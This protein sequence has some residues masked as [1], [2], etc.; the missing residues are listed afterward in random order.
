[1]NKKSTIASLID[2]ASDHKKYYI[3][4]VI[5][6]V[7]GVACS[8]LPYYLVARIVVD[9]VNGVKDFNNY[10]NLCVI[11]MVSWFLRVLFH[12]IS[13]TLS[14]KAT[15]TVIAN[16]RKRSIEKLANMPLGDVLNIPS[17]TMKSIIV[18]KIDSIETTLAHVVPEITSN[19]LVPFAIVIYIFTIDWRMALASLITVP[20]GI[21]CYMM[22][23]KDYEKNYGNYIN[24]NKILNATS[25]EYVA[26]IQVIKAFNQSA[27]SYEK[28]TKAAYEA[29]HSAIDWMEKCNIYFSIALSVFPAVLIG[30]LPIGCM[31]YIN[32]SLTSENFINI[33]ILALGVM[34]PLITAVSYSDDIAKI[35]T[36][37]GDINSVLE[38]DNLNRPE[39]LNKKLSFNNIKL[40]NVCFS[41]DKKQVLN[42]VDLNIKG[43]QVNA[44]VGPSGGGKSTIAKL[45]ASLWDVDK[46]S[47]EIGGINIKDIPLEILNEK[48]AYVSQDNYLFNDTIMNNIRMG[49]LKASDEDVKKVARKSG[50]EEFIL[51]LENGY[52][53]ITGSSGGH[54]SGGERQRISIARAMLKD[55]DI[56]ILDEATA[57]TDPENEVILQKAVGKLVKGKT[58]IVIAHRLSTIIDASQIIVVNNGKIES[59]G[60]HEEL[61]KKCKLYKDMWIAHN[62]VKDRKEVAI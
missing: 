59:K 23:M 37:I 3:I 13:T 48:I 27:S 45:I 10:V 31:F 46:G 28:F 39:V 55:A 22:M 15:F 21:L 20:L 40:K 19:L 6:A 33:I 58:L 53:T 44:L 25:V 54:L 56:V 26:G 32:G 51:K 42:N 50:C 30:V 29:A 36:I 11:C 49:N 60:T 41:Y 34:T 4:S 17:G 43:G 9:L 8:I 61:L 18:E 5:C 7:I 2:F 38:K 52:N 62:S 16:V 57:Y 1:M 12:S 24:K 35:K 14:H 47:I